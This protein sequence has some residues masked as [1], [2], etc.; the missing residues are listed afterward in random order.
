[1]GKV[2]VNG[3]HHS[4]AVVLDVWKVDVN[5]LLLSVA[6]RS[7]I[8]VTALMLAARYGESEA[9]KLLCRRGARINETMK[10]G[11][12]AVIIAAFVCCLLV[13]DTR[14]VSHLVLLLCS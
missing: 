2:D 10:D 9:A 8:A 14:D 3:Q 6:D 13:F 1:V 12:S 7:D 4:V 11:V 5:G